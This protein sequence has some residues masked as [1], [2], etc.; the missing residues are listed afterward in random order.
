[1]VVKCICND[2]SFAEMKEFMSRENIH[3]FEELAG[4]MKIADNCALC[5]PYIRK[6]TETG[7][8]EFGIIRESGSAEFK[9]FSIRDKQI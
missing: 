8:T 2:I 7:E 9:T 5:V 3:L 4:L 6:M 1:M